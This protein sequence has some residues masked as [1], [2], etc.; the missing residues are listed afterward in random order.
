MGVMII[1][2]PSYD[3]SDLPACGFSTASSC[4]WSNE[5]YVGYIHRV[6]KQRGKAYLRCVQP[7]YLPIN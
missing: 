2:H 3:T 4:C 7:T 6:I 5:L 1:L